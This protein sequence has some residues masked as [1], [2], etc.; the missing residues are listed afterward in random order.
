MSAD[1][2]L[3]RISDFYRLVSKPVEVVAKVEMLINGKE[4]EQPLKFKVKVTKDQYGKYWGI[5]SH[6]IGGHVSLEAQDSIE[7]AIE[8]ALGGLP[9]YLDTNRPLREQLTPYEEY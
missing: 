4:N 2:D 8:D 3:K 1:L 7:L 5:P 9:A 6:R